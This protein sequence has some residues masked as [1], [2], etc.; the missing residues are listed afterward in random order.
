[1]IN[2][3]AISKEGFAKALSKFMSERSLEVSTA[4]P[5]CKARNVNEAVRGETRLNNYIDID[6]QLKQLEVGTVL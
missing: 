2:G 1:M 4:C 3:E 5:K 6:L